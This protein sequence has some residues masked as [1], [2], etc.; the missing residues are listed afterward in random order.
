MTEPPIICSADSLGWEIVFE[1]EEEGQRITKT[2]LPGFAT[3]YEDG[4][5]YVQGDMRVEFETSGNVYDATIDVRPCSESSTG[6]CITVEVTG[7]LLGDEPVL[8]TSLS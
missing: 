2:F 4:K 8:F 3:R 5:Q 6:H 1:C 7:G